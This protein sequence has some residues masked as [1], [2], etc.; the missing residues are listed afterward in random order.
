M[1]DKTKGIIGM[2]LLAPNLIM[3]MITLIGSFNNYWF[4]VKYLLFSLIIPGV[5]TL[6]IFRKDIKNEL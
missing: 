4:P 3:M 5:Y 2:V 6:L 1:K